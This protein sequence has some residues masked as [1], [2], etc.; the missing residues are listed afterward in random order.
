[1]K[2][3]IGKKNDPAQIRQLMDHRMK[4]ASPKRIRTSLP[5]TPIPPST[6]RTRAYF[7]SVRAAEMAAWEMTGGDY[8]LSCFVTQA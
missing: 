7:R 2:T 4:T 3:A 8:V 1:M 5:L 6:A